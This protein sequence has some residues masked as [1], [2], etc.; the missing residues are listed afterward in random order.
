MA[1][2]EKS[3]TNKRKGKNKFRLETGFH[4][5]LYTSGKKKKNVSRSCFQVMN[6]GV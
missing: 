1:S 2:N 5:I 4:K 6:P 3:R